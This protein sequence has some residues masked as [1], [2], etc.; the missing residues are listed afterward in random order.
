ME[1]MIKVKGM[2]CKS[3]EILVADSVSEISG[4]ESV[5]ADSRK[6][7]VVVNVRDAGILGRVKAAIEKEGYKVEN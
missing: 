1:K 7:T 3:C 2:H 6:G 4:V 5:K